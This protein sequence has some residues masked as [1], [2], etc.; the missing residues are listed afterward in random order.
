M[1]TGRGA[2]TA[3]LRR[4]RSPR[5]P[6]ARR[7]P[8]VNTARERESVIAPAVPWFT[9][10]SNAYHLALAGDPRRSLV[11]AA[12]PNRDLDG[13]PATYRPS[14]S[15][16]PRRP[17]PPGRRARS[18]PGASRRPP[19]STRCRRFRAWAAG[20][21]FSAMRAS[22]LPLAGSILITDDGFAVRSQTAPPSTAIPVPAARL[23]VQDALVARVLVDPGQVGAE[24]VEDPDVSAS[25][26]EPAGAR[27]DLDPVDELVGLRVDAV[28]LSRPHRGRPRRCRRRAPQHRDTR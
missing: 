26:G 21:G 3:S 10:G 18:R 9:A 17:A 8:G 19:P 12:T 1:L 22:T 11:R 4:S 28:D 6:R 25:G 24:E 16:S 5:G 15:P 13:R 27:V 20:G 2:G 7:R 23:I 14:P